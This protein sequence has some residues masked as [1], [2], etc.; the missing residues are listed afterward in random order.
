M[1]ACRIWTTCRCAPSSMPWASK[2]EDRG[3]Q[4]ETNLTT[5]DWTLG[6]SLSVDILFLSNEHLEFG[7]WWLLGGFFKRIWHLAFT[8]FISE[9]LCNVSH[10]LDRLINVLLT[11]LKTTKLNSSRTTV[12]QKKKICLTASSRFNI[13]RILWKKGGETNLIIFETDTEHWCQNLFSNFYKDMMLQNHTA[14][15][16]KVAEG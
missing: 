16:N 4:M 11:A 8:L 15:V 10:S 7:N 5:I 9:R 12:V 6:S 3:E 13:Y 14:G 1:W 2:G